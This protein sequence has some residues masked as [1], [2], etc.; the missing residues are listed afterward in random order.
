MPG[1]L[2]SKATV[3]LHLP[4]VLCAV[5]VV[6]AAIACTPGPG[7]AADRDA[8]SRVTES[9]ATTPVTP[10]IEESFVVGKVRSMS[11]EAVDDHLLSKTGIVSRRQLVEIEIREGPLAGSTVVVPNEIT[12]NP[13]YNVTVKPGDEVVLSV[14]TE[15]GAKPE[16]NIADHHR[17]PVL[18]YLLALFL[19]CF[20]WFGGKQGAK[21][22]IG[23]V[24]CALMI[25]FVLL[26]LSMR[27]VNPLLTAT[28]IC[29]VAATASM[30]LVAGMSRKSWSAIVGT[31]G[32]VIVAGLAAQVVIGTAHLTGLSSEEAQ[33]LRGS[34]LV[35]PGHFYSG[36]LAA[37]MLIGALGVIMDVAISIASTVWEVSCADRTLSASQLYRSGMNVG[38]DIMGTMTNTLV[39][40][41]AGGA[42]PLLL[43]ASQ[44]P[45]SKLLNLDLLATEIAATLSGSLGLVLTIP[46]TALVASRWM[47]G[48]PAGTPAQSPPDAEQGPSTTADPAGSDADTQTGDAGKVPNA[49][50]RVP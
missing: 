19:A 26:P 39:L 23:L 46:L 45:S 38:R 47:S 37:G 16:I 33:I 49:A 50:G 31:V 42:L 12:D 24:L 2:G 35:Q 43:L 17:V 5:F 27:G 15:N 32:G 29:L 14:T 40:A 41:Y 44:I 18:A 4:R 10:R 8:Q 1:R 3:T 6:M 13:A 21:S 48:R 36:L 11:A 30:L 25:C 9:G 28:F 34:V 20:L 7:W 22:L